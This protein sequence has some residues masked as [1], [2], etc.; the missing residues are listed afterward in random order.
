MKLTPKQLTLTQ[1]QIRGQWN[2]SNHPL[3]KDCHGDPDGR[4]GEQREAANE[5]AT[6]KG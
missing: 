2:H 4:S 5:K 1:R 3:L 6:G